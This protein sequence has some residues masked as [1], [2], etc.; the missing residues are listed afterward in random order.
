[1]TFTL[2]NYFVLGWSLTTLWAMY[3]IS[4]AIYKAPEKED[5]IKTLSKLK[6]YQKIVIFIGFLF[7]ILVMV[8][9]GYGIYIDG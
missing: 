1:M 6:I 3:I 9:L 5:T 8:G 2:E 7:M 4:Y